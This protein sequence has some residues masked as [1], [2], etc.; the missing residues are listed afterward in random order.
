MLR[1]FR[2]IRQNLI[3]KNKMG[4]YLMYAIGEVALVIIGIMIAVSLNNINE[5][6]SQDQKIQS[7]L[8]QIQNELTTTIEDANGMIEYFRQKDSLIYVVMNRK[9]TREDFKKPENTVLRFLSTHY[10]TLIMQNDGFNNL[11]QK[12]E[13]LPDKYIPIVNGLKQLYIN[14][15]G[16]VDVT[17]KHL[18]DIVTATIDHQRNTFDW[19]ADYNFLDGPLTDEILDYYLNDGMYRN[20]LVDYSNIAIENLLPNII[21]VRISAIKYIR[22]IDALLETSNTYSFDVNG[23]DYKDWNG[24]YHFQGDTVQ[25]DN[26]EEGMKWFNEGEW[27]EIYPLSKTKFH[28][29]SIAFL[30]FVKDENDEIN[31]I[32]IHFTNTNIT[33]QKIIERK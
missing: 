3:E 25:I 13:I 18:E 2:V 21:D 24:K 9:V 22:E 4:R 15:K 6:K 33:Y 19:Y 32:N 27:A 12:S 16:N 8:K 26:D 17:N 1:F 7:T 23:A 20:S 30:Q 28:F 31:G 10:A 14:R 5:A 11:M 29:L